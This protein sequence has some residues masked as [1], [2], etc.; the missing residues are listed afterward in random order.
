MGTLPLHSLKVS[1]ET[2]QLH[3]LTRSLCAFVIRAAFVKRLY[4]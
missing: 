3:C 1:T 4:S 2:R